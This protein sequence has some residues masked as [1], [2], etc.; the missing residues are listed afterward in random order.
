MPTV[1][2]NGTVIIAVAD[3]H[4]NEVRV[5]YTF[6]PDIVYLRWREKTET[7]DDF[8]RRVTQFGETGKP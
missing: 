5:S 7:Y 1:L 6:K 2:C 4:G 3:A 8:V